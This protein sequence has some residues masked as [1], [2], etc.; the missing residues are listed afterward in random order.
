MTA[1]LRKPAENAEILQGLAT[2]GPPFVRSAGMVKKVLCP[3][4]NRSVDPNWR[5]QR[6]VTRPTNYQLGR[7]DDA[8]QP[9]TIGPYRMA[10]IKF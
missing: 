7:L 1:L 5:A 9:S 8:R 3:V 6:A 2:N 4:L 10:S